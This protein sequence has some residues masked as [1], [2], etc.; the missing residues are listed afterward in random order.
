MH[1]EIVT[2]SSFAKDNQQE[3]TPSSGFLENT[4]HEKN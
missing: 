3:F 4:Q 1:Q 2:T